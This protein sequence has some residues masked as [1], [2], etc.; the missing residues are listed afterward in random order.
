MTNDLFWRMFGATLAAERTRRQWSC[1]DVERA[2]GPVST[3]VG[4]HERGHIR[5][6]LAL[7]RHTDA[8]GWQLIELI[9]QLCAEHFGKPGAAVSA[10]AL[11]T[12]RRFEALEADAQQA[13]EL[14]VLA[15]ET[16]T[17]KSAKRAGS[18]P[19]PRGTGGGTVRQ[20]GVRP[21]K[22]KRAKQARRGDA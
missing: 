22:A 2:G 21:Q 12:A 9:A 20:R 5:T 14:M 15:F 8:L 6:L 13:V 10:G 16:G 4:Q 17:A 18:P 3:T 11:A 7:S 1:R 19:A